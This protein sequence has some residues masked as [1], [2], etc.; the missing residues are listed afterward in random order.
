MSIDSTSTIQGDDKYSTHDRIAMP[1][2]TTYVLERATY[3]GCGT[4]SPMRNR[5]TRWAS[6]ATVRGDPIPPTL[7]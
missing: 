1:F 4:P 2:S 5:E 7:P 6:P 3:I